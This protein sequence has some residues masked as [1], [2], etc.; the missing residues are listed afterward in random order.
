MEQASGRRAWALEKL[1][2]VWQAV[3]A[4]L[5]PS[6]LSRPMPELGQLLRDS[7]FGDVGSMRTLVPWQLSQPAMAMGSPPAAWAR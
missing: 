6:G 3:H 7:L 4:P 2:R 5:L 1:W